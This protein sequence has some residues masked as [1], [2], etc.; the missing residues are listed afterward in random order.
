MFIREVFA[1]YMILLFKWAMEKRIATGSLF[2]A[3]CFVAV[4]A[5]A[6]YS[7]REFEAEQ[8]LRIHSELMVIGL[9][10]IK[11]PEGDGLYRKYQSF[12]A[13]HAVL[14]SAYESDLLAY[15][16][17]QGEA[18]P[19][20]KLHTLRTNL[21]NEISQHAVSMSTLSFCRKFS[22]HLDAA[23]GMDQAKLRRWALN[24]RSGQP[25]AEPACAGMAQRRN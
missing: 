19:D 14:L 23:L 15:Y 22:S 3:L 10:C 4:R 6:C 9:T 12:T 1:N 5:E 13:K 17:R 21:A 24:A 2:L 11:M 20:R 16:K 8:G 18:A 7:A 25:T